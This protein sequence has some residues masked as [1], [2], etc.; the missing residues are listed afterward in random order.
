MP[1][2]RPTPQHLSPTPQIDSNHPAIV[3]FAQQHA[4]GAG[5]REKAISLYLAVRDRVRY[6]PYRIDLSDLGMTASTALAQGF[7]WCVP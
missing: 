1:T 7:G 6:D 5:E 4:Q 3:A 2:T